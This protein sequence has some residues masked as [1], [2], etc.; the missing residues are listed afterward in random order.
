MRA[1]HAGAAGSPKLTDDQPLPIHTIG[2]DQ[3]ADSNR[4]ALTGGH[5]TRPQGGTLLDRL[6]PNPRLV[7][8]DRVDLAATPAATWHRVRHGSFV[9]SRLAKTLFAIRTLPDRLRGAT[10]EVSLRIDDLRS[11]SEHPGFQVLLES[12]NREVVVGAIGKVWMSRIPFLHLPDA[13]EYAAFD[14][15]GYVKVAWCFRVAP[16]NGGSHLEMEVRVDATDEESWRKFRRYFRVIGPASRFIRRSGLAALA[17]E[18]GRPSPL[19]N[20]EPLPGDD[21]LPDAAD[22]LTHTDDVAATPEK[23]WPW[24]VQMGCN[25]AGFYSIDLLDNAARRSAREIHPEL[26]NLHVG[27]L[28]PATPDEGAGFEVLRIQKPHAL[29]LGG[30][31]DPDKEVQLPFAAPRPASFWHVTWAFVL[32]PLDGRSTRIHARA[33]VAYSKSGRLQSLFRA[34]IH[35]LMERAQLRNLAE[36]VEGRGWRDDWRDVLQGMKG[37]AVMAGSLLTPFWKG[38]RSVWGV[39]EETAARRHPGDALVPKPAW[40]WTHGV[41]INASAKEV[42]PWVAQI[43]AD[44]GGFYSYQWLEN[45]AGC[46]LRN[47]ET[48]HPQW[49]VSAGDL[50]VLH[51]K[52]PPFRVLAK[53]RDHYFIAYAPADER[54]R[55]AGKP[56]VEASWLFQVESL[57][58]ERS[59][60]ISRY[61]V[62]LSGEWKNRV[63]FGPALVEPVGYAMDREMLQ[64]VKRRVEEARA[65]AAH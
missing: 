13:H 52:V 45:L 23:V 42:W 62:D 53:E 43:G 4:T 5:G 1:N 27:E 57:G 33:R 38:R 8:I 36:R 24:L 7:E 64:G 14:M 47:A 40:S 11:S 34:P 61:R 9:S 18:L 10:T 25:R 46:A 21:L 56:W 59:R 3:A 6:I 41:E 37:V 65:R 30:L 26:Q 55:R 2:P 16:R 29:V 60:L 63:A 28:I 35:H 32:E 12:P 51:P 48:V 49:E 58:P 22:Q 17:G 44:R 20:T 15:T 50:L 31:W 39:D 19:E 54:A